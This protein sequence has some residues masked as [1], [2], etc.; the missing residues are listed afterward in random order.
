MLLVMRQPRDLVQSVDLGGPFVPFRAGATIWFS[1]L[2]LI[3]VLLAGCLLAWL[4]HAAGRW[5]TCAAG[6]CS[7]VRQTSSA[8][9]SSPSPSAE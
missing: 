7:R 1:P 4:L 3:T 9:V 6:G 8:R 5:S 2:G